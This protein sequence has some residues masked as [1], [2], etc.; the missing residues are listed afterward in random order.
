MQNSKMGHP[1]Q[2]HQNNGIPPIQCLSYFHQ[3]INH[4]SEGIGV[5]LSASLN[6]HWVDAGPV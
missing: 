6:R 2:N 3:S 5:L 1:F 4:P